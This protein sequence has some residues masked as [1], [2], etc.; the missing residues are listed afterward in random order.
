MIAPSDTS[1]SGVRKKN[2]MMVLMR[3]S[4]VRY[5][6]TPRFVAPTP[7]DIKRLLPSVVVRLRKTVPGTTAGATCRFSGV[8][9]QDL[10]CTGPTI[11]PIELDDIDTR[12]LIGPGK[13]YRSV[14]KAQTVGFDIV[15]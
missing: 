6:H 1:I 9:P 7:D 14:I 4:A 10:S 12:R 8:L 11:A 2:L 15:P 5:S 3:R 13:Q